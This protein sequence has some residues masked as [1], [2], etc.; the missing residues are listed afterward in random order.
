MVM[1]VE[2]RGVVGT[3]ME[4]GVAEGGCGRCG[5]GDRVICSMGML[6]RVAIVREERMG[7]VRSWWLC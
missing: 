2:G 1:W 4:M 7:R 3:E 5:F 6:A